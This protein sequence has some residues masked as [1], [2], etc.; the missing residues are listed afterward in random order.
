MR[1]ASTPRSRGH[2]VPRQFGTGEKPLPR[3]RRRLFVDPRLPPRSRNPSMPLF[4]AVMPFVGCRP[5]QSSQPGCCLMLHLLEHIGDHQNPLETRPLSRRAKRRSSAAPGSLRKK[6]TDMIP[7]PCCR[8]PIKFYHILGS[9]RIRRIPFCWR[10]LYSTRR[11]KCLQG[12]ITTL[13]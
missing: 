12:V 13:H 2:L 10:V 4:I 9:A 3:P 1:W 11:L 6:Y 7:S 8:Y 5:A